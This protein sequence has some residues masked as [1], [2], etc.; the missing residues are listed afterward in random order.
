MCVW[1]GGGGGGG[2]GFRYPVPPSSKFLC[3][4][5]LGKFVER[6]D[7]PALLIHRY[8]MVWDVLIPRDLHQAS[9]ALEFAILA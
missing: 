3:T 8:R 9:I 1:G 4:V 6:P 2:G 7:T 5:A